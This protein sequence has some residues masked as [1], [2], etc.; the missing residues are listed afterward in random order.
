MFAFLPTSNRL[1]WSLGRIKIKHTYIV[2]IAKS[3]NGSM[4][5]NA[6]HLDQGVLVW[7]WNDHD[8][9]PAMILSPSFI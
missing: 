4:E 8:Y 3:N 1:M 5:K 6:I 7:K 2:Y 9:F